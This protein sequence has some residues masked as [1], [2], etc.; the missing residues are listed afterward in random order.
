MKEQIQAAIESL[1]LA[2]NDEACTAE[3]YAEIDDVIYTLTDMIE[4]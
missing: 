1:R 3:R 4:A 2:Q